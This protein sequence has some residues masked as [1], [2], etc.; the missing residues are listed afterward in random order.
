[1]S[2][3]KAPWREKGY[4]PEYSPSGRL[5][6]F[7]TP[8][9]KYL[10]YRQYR[11]Q[12]GTPIKGSPG[13]KQRQKAKE[14]GI[15]YRPPAG[16]KLQAMREFAKKNP[17][18]TKK[19]YQSGQE[20]TSPNTRIRTKHNAAVQKQRRESVDF[21][22]QIGELTKKQADKA[23]ELIKETGKLRGE[24]ARQYDVIHLKPQQR[25]NKEKSIRKYEKKTAKY[26][27]LEQQLRK[28]G[29][30][31]QEDNYLAHGYYH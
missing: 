11:K 8:Q 21:L 27:K 20:P 25:A 29:I 19:W 31:M 4:K 22:E 5:K 6:G 10:S 13:Y 23:R 3:H 28:Y 7:T 26:N 16:A 14:K 17:G 12:I 30:V 24:L 18:A 1:M 2:K 9:G 15:D